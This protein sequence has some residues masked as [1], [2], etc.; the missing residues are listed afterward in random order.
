MSPTGKVPVVV[1]D[2]DSL[3]ESNVV[4]QDLDEVFELPNFCRKTRRSGPMLGSGWPLPTTTSSRLSSSL[5]WEAS[6]GS[7]RSR[8]LRPWRS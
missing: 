8:A 3:Y 2:G 1:V 5:A 7:L 6:E 4:N